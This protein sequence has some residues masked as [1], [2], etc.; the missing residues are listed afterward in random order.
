MSG[1]QARFLVRYNVN[2][3]PVDEYLSV[4]TRCT[5]NTRKFGVN[6]VQMTL[7][8]CYAILTRGRTRQGQLEAMQNRFQTIGKSVAIN[9][10]WNEKWQA[11]VMAAAQDRMRR[12]T[13]AIIKRG[14]EMRAVQQRQHEQFLATM[15]RGTNMS[16]Q[17][18]KESMDA[19]S[20]VA[21]DWADYALDLQKRRDP[22]TGQE[23]KDSS[24]YSYTWI[25]EFG[26]R[27]Q[28][29]NPN[30]NPNGVRKG[31]W[32]LQENVR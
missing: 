9:Q 1:D 19:R 27:Y 11:A 20:R 30:D 5:E 32:V 16:I 29:N 24:Q 31:N 10:Q 2:N 3:I 23:T 14:E 17:R 15:Q 12:G 26:E 18:T 8:A 6:Q 21:D 22:V 28:T 4:T 7:Y 13:D 25:N